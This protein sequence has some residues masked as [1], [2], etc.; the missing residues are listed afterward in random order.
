MS[1]QQKNRFVKVTHHAVCDPNLS[2]AA[3]RVLAYL[4]MRQNYDGEA[5]P[6]VK[7]IASDL[8]LKDCSWIR[9][10]LRILEERGYIITRRRRHQSSRYFVRYDFPPSQDEGST[11][12]G[13]RDEPSGGARDEPST[14]LD[15]ANKT[16]GTRS[17][18]GPPQGDGSLFEGD[19][20][21]ASSETSG[22]KKQEYPDGFLRFW[23]TWPA[24]KRKKDKYKAFVNWRKAKRRGFSD[25]DLTLAAER[26][27]KLAHA[28]Q[29]AWEYLK[30]PQFWLS[31]G[32]FE[33]FL[34]ED[35]KQT[36]QQLKPPKDDSWRYMV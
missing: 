4:A 32:T 9:Q 20:A 14:E 30:A 18:S 12:G 28:D 2:H 8:N 17:P 15:P 11:L 36:K 33:A 16:Q 13:A 5:W 27:A 19:A 1:T 25:D 10:V 21:P 6:A 26:Q 34:G 23:D 3:F 31:A 35:W 22:Q 29:D 24:H 7:T